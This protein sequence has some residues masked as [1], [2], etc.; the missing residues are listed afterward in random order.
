MK[1]HINIHY[2]NSAFALQDSYLDDKQPLGLTLV[3]Q[4][5]IH[6][7]NFYKMALG[8]RPGVSLRVAILVEGL[9]TY[10]LNLVILYA[11]SESCSKHARVLKHNKQGCI[12][13]HKCILH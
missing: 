10:F 11:T 13:Y 5:Q 12:T 1:D 2:I 6:C 7:R 3:S 8:P 9:L 4:F